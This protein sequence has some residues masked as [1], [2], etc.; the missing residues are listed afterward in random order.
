[1][2][3]PTRERTTLDFLAAVQPDELHDLKK[4]LDKIAADLTD[5]DLHQLL[6]AREQLKTR[7]TGLASLAT[8]LRAVLLSLAER[9]GAVEAAASRAGSAENLRTRV[10]SFEAV[11]K[12]MGSLSE[13]ERS[14]LQAAARGT[15][16]EPIGQVPVEPA[17]DRSSASDIVDGRLEDTAAAERA[18]ASDRADAEPTVANEAPSVFGNVFD[19]A[20]DRMRRGTRGPEQ[21]GFVP[22]GQHD[23]PQP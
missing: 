7:A 14:V 1:M 6:S 18:D 9:L 19:A 13:I 15:Q 21:P 16:P 5:E 10:E 3:G 8:M 12:V 4:W 23:V 22:Q 2:P 20:L 17:S 11:A